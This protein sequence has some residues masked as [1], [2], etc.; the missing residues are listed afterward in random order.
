LLGNDSLTGSRGN[1]YV[2]NNEGIV[3]K[4][5]FLL[6]PPLRLYNENPRPA[7]LELRESF[8]MARKELAC[9]LKTLCEL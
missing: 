4:R 1:E 8:E 6:Y 7:E 3:T 5:Y 2:S 9:D